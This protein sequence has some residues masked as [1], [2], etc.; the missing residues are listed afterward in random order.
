MKGENMILS[1]KQIKELHIISEYIG[2]K[3]FQPAGVDLT[4]KRLFKYTTSGLIDFDNSKR[5]VSDV[6]E[7]KLSDEPRHIPQGE[8]KVMINEYI[9]IPSDVVG[10][11]FPRSSLLRSGATVNCA[12]WDPGYEGR[13]EFLLSVLNKNG[14][15]ITKN[16]RI[17]QIVF[18]RMEKE[19]DELY[20]G[21]YHRENLTNA[22]SIEQK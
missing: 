6:E 20:K 3:Q 16:A 21:V 17:S 7:I 5:K 2:E 8:Y 22:H 4:I 9:K 14:I 1:E 18:I 15:S 12:V 19:A 10:L 11:C 13:G